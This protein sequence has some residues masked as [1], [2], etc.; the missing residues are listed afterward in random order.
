M[1]TPTNY[2]MRLAL[3]KFL[4]SRVVE[5]ED[6]DGVM[7]QGIFIPLAMNGM[8]V[9]NKGNVNAYAFVNE[10]MT[11]SVDG[12]SHYIRLNIPPQY[13]KEVNKL[14]YELPYIGELK[15]HNHIPKYQ[16]DK[17]SNKKIAKVSSLKHIEEN[18][19]TKI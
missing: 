9:T 1:D 19:Y 12:S 16:R 10:R 6:A 15:P 8:H 11:V 14:G 7:E 17:I 13:L 3:T 5:I 4:G 18:E 2:T